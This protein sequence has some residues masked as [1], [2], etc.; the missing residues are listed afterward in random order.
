[1]NIKKILYTHLSCD[2]YLRTL[3]RSFFFLYKLGLLRFN[4]NYTCHYFV[5]K[6]IKKGDTVVDIGANLGYYSLLFAKWVGKEGKV[7]A[8]EPVPVYQK[9]FNEKAKKYHNITLLP[10]A[11]GKE[12]R[13][14]ELILVV[15][16]GYLRTG[17]SHV[18]HPEKDND[19]AKNG[20]KV[21]AQMKIAS[22]LFKNLAKINY[23]KIDIEGDEYT[24]LLDL[25]ELILRHKPIIQ[26][27]MNDPQIKVFLEQFGYTAHQFKGDCLFFPMVIP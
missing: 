2:N 27:E 3:Q 13:E 25:K 4:N 18:Y 24:V 9:I 15:S 22:T 21:P 17:L 6:L 20:F 5:K 14:V 1:M 7:Y 19:P 10:Y 8:V 12:E 26:V 16:S 11:L 23:I